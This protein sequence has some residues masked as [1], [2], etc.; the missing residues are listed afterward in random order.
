MIEPS[1]PFLK[2]KRKMPLNKAKGNMYPWVTETRNPLGG[3]CPHECSY[4]WVP[5][6][7]KRHPSLR[8]KYSGPIRLIEKE[9][10]R[11]LGSGKT[12][13]VGSCNDLFAEDVP[14]KYIYKILE[15]C[16]LWPDNTYVFQTKNPDRFRGFN[17][18]FFP[19]TL[20]GTT[21]ETNRDTSGISRVPSPLDRWLAFKE[22]TDFIKFI[23][24]EPLFNFDLEILVDWI[25]L[26]KP[27]F[28]NIGADSKGHGLC[29]PEAWKVLALIEAVRG[30]GIEVREKS[31]LSRLKI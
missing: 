13:F 4:C 3:A 12:I 27:D 23:T 6:L 25:I 28:V 29:E 5:D 18:Y 10:K 15:H 14:A 19:N 21:I 8:E 30:A 11:K 31:N 2:K 26:A 16:L 24:L 17:T 1:S 7:A 22:I 20:L 9:L